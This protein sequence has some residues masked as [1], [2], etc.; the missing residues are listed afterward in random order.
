MV[1]CL[2]VRNLKSRQDEVLSLTPNIHLFFG[3]QIV[4]NP[5]KHVIAI[6]LQWLVFLTRG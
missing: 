6:G 4:N 3:V 2:D 1:R 5:T